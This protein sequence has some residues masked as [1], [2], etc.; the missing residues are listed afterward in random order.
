[1]Q[2]KIERTK[3]IKSLEVDIERTKR[4]K[5]LE[6]KIEG[7]RGSEA[8]ETKNVV[9]KMDGQEV[10]TESSKEKNVVVER[11]NLNDQGVEVA[12]VNSN[13]NEPDVED[14]RMSSNPNE[15]FFEEDRMAYVTLP[16]TRWS[17]SKLRRATTRS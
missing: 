9:S 5:R 4:R 1:L 17:T 11:N 8:N 13:P 3:R 14:K 12:S 10:D 15:P 7:I 6:G 2:V 16:M